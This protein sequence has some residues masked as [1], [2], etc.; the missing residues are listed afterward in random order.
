MEVLEQFGGIDLVA[1]FGPQHGF[2]ATTQDNMVEWRGFTH[3]RLG[4][5]VHS[6]YGEHREP[7][8]A[9][10]EGLEALVVDLVDVGARYYTFVWTLFLCMKACETAGVPVIVCDRPNPI[11]GVTVEGEPQDPA[12]LSFVGLRPLPVRHGRTIG[13]LA[14]MFRDE[15]FPG[16]RLEVL[17]MRGWDREMWQDDTG[18]PWVLPSP[19][20]P[21]LD[22]ATVYPG[23]C[24]LEG[25]NLSEGRGTT[26]P[27][28]LFGAPWI[29]REALASRLNALGL[30]GAWFRK[31][32]FEPTFQKC[33]GAVCHGAQLHV[34]NRGEF[35][36]VRTGIEIIRVVR[37]LWPEEFAWKQP[38]YE[39]EYEK[40]PIEILAGGPVEKLFP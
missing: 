28:E 9:M 12:Y 7:T 6:L 23:M 37:D 36:P 10:L 24:L 33:A 14:R 22:T 19:N 26:R 31:A 3:P 1:L 21:T 15:D 11:N 29:D 4:I 34:T 5:P 8:P 30:P 32:S 18:L 25:T 20:M 17:P 35:L 40:L 27:F 38:P 13:E 39:Y 16:C 2:T